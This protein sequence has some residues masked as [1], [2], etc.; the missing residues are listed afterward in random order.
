MEFGVQKSTGSQKCSSRQCGQAITT[1]EPVFLTTSV[2]FGER[3]SCLGFHPKCVQP[4]QVSSVVAD[5]NQVEGWKN[6]NEELKE[7]VKTAF[8]EVLKNKVKKVA[9]PTK[10]KPD[11]KAD[12]GKATKSSK[13]NTPA[14]SKE[15]SAKSEKSEKKDGGPK[16][17]L[18]AYVLFGMAERQNIIDQ[19]GGTEAVKVS[20]VMGLVG[21][22]WRVAD[23]DT[24][25]KFE[26]EAVREKERF[27]KQKK[28]FDETGK[29]TKSA[30]EVEA[31][32][33]RDEK[34]KASKEKEKRKREEKKAEKSSE[35][36]DKETPGPED[37][38]PPAE[39][40][41]VEEDAEEPTKE[42]E[43]EDADAGGE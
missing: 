13:T 19:N 10:R 14:K 34:A 7:E 6:F 11:A 27:A 23:A 2:S 37:A 43:V 21:A 30:D 17:P 4:D 31:D 41:E 20:E 3:G 33:V 16:K 26:D 25:K 32:R 42:D 15:K 5:W 39:E 35:K 24:K 8:E 12:S 22:A 29:F 18:S 1:G 40:E 9:T 38:A 36:V 28:E